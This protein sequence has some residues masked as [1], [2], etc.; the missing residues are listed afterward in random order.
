LY[1]KI[2]KIMNGR[3]ASLPCLA[4]GNVLPDEGIPRR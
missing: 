2:H 4:P 3:Q 1:A